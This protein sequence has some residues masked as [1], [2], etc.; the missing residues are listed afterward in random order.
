MPIWSPNRNARPAG[1][2]SEVIILHSTGGKFAGALSWMMSKAGRVSAHY[3]VGRD[4]TVRKLVPLSERAW[5]AGR[6][7]WRGRADVNDFS[8]GVEMEHIDGRQ[9]WPERQVL[10]VRDLIRDIRHEH[11]QLPVTSHA[12]I[13]QPPGRKRDPVGFPWE[14][15]P[16][17][18]ER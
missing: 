15:L 6:S 7:L 11:G 10:A 3:L 17:P 5:H 4:G 13:A 8:I 14:R 16:K 2:K 9:D 1:C 18:W 12:H